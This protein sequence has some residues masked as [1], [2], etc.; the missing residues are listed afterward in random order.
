MVEGTVAGEVAELDGDVDGSEVEGPV[1]ETS[2]HRLAP[3]PCGAC[4]CRCA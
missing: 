1:G 2:W 4:P 3:G